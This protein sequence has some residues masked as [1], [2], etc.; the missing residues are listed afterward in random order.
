MEYSVDSGQTWNIL[1]N[2][3]FQ[4]LSKPEF[5]AQLRVFGTGGNWVFENLDVEFIRGS[6][7]DIV[8]A[9]EIPQL[10]E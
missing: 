3:A 10:F 6:I 4:S 9:L 1:P 7:A 8:V 2:N 5:S